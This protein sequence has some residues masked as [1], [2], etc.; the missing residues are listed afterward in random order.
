MKQ[1]LNGTRISILVEDGFEQEVSAVMG[2]ESFTSLSGTTGKENAIGL[3]M[4]GDIDLF[5]ERR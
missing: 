5:Q 2:E 4:Q 3:A 1:Q